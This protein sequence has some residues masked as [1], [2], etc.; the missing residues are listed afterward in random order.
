MTE[1]WTGK[2]AVE[3]SRGLIF[4]TTPAFSWRDWRKSRNPS[5]K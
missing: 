3:D 5:A 1:Y 4:G 2:L